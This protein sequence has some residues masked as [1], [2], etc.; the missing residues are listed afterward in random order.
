MARTRA[1]HAYNAAT[2]SPDREDARRWLRWKQ[3]HVPEGSTLEFPGLT[4]MKRRQN[5]KSH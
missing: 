3:S 2:V 1:V 5:S 4:A